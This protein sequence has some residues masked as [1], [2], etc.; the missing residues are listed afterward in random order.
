MI[1]F[2]MALTVQARAAEPPAQE[3][4]PAPKTVME[5]RTEMAAKAAS[6]WLPEDQIA[7]TALILLDNGKAG[8]GFFLYVG[9]GVY[10]VTA[11]H[12]LCNL[13]SGELLAPKAQ[14]L[15][16]PK[17]SESGRNVFSLNLALL[18]ERGSL[19]VH[20]THDVA[21]VRLGKLKSLPVP[22]KIEGVPGVSSVMKSS[23]G[24]TGT[25]TEAVK[26]LREVSVSN[27]TFVIGFPIS[28]GGPFGENLDRFA[29]LVKR[30]AVAGV[31][32]RDGVII[33]DA[34]VYP[35][36]SGGVVVEVTQNGFS[37]E[38]RGIGLVSKL[39]PYVDQDKATGL[40]PGN[41]GYA[42]VEPMDHVLELVDKA[43]R[44]YVPPPEA[45]KTEGAAK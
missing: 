10:L 34:A 44:E 42:V 13:R 45:P 24:I 28:L 5:L 16:Y 30:G 23:S 26:L 14:A 19:R 2:A 33:L 32:E 3:N 17:R 1:S 37:R 36:N 22:S 18:K 38:F 31:S 12:V 39:V 41:S 11:K 25:S 40:S 35:G 29:P 9:Q 20:A 6:P 8:S 7:N 15:S 21:V 27:E 43:D 4:A